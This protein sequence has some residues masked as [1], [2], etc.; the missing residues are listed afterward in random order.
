MTAGQIAKRG[1]LTADD[2]TARA[3]ELLMDEGVSAVKI[4]RLCGDLGVTKGSFYWR[5]EDLASLKESIAAKW[6]GDSTQMLAGLAELTTL[7]PWDRLRTMTVALVDERAWSVQRALREWAR[8]DER[9]AAT[10][11]EGDVLAFDLIRRAI[12]ELGVSARRAR[13][14]AGLLVYAGIGFVHGP[15]ALFRPAIGDLDDLMDF[16]A[17]DAPTHA[18]VDQPPAT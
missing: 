14:R 15:S 1:A 4:S 5:F 3:L 7:E 16:L 6:C 12:E 18:G 10:I 8:T 11:A 9:V 17:G 13:L 2:W